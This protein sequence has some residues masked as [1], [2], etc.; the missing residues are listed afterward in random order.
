MKTTMFTGAQM[1]VQS[2]DSYERV[3][4]VDVPLYPHMRLNTQNLR[5]RGI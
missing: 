5:L 4:T 3:A 2:Y 1:A